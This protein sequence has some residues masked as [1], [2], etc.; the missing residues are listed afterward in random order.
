MRV[1]VALALGG[2]ALGLGLPAGAELRD[3]DVVVLDTGLG[4]IVQIDPATGNRTLFS[5][6]GA[7]P[8]LSGDLGLVQTPDTRVYVTD[9]SFRIVVL[10]DPW[11][12]ARGVASGMLGFSDRGRGPAFGAPGAMDATPDGR[13]LV[14]DPT[15]DAVFAVDARSG[16]RSIL[17][18]NSVGIGP[19]FGPGFGDPNA[20]AR[21]ASGRVLVG[22]GSEQ[23]YGVDPVTGDRTVLTGPAP[24]DESL[25]FRGI[26]DLAAESEPGFLV[27][28]TAQRSLFRVDGSTG[29]RSVVSSSNPA[30]LRGS[31][32]A[33]SLPLGLEVGPRGEILVVDAG[34]RALLAVDPQTGDRRIVSGTGVGTGPAFS[35]PRQVLVSRFPDPGPPGPV[36][37]IDTNSRLYD[38]DLATG[39]AIRRDFVR[40]AAGGFLSG[41][42]IGIDRAPAPDGRLMGLTTAG[43]LYAVDPF[44]A[45][46]RE[47][48]SIGHSIS[49]GDIAFDP[50]TGDLYA[51][52]GTPDGLVLL[53]IDV[54]TGATTRLQSFGGV[55]PDALVFRPDGLLELVD[56]FGKRVFTIDPAS[57]AIL[58]VRP[59]VFRFPG[60]GGRVELQG[61]QG[62]AVW[63]AAAD[64][65]R[66]VGA[67]EVLELPRDAEEGTYRATLGPG[68]VVLSGLTYY[69]NA[70]PTAE[71]GPDQSVE[72]SSPAGAAVTLDGS[73]SADPEGGELAFRWTN[74][75][76]AAEGAQ[77]TVE[78]PL[79]VSLVTL[80]VDDGSGGTGA[81]EVEVRVEDTTPPEV[82]ASLERLRG[83]SRRADR[84]DDDERERWGGKGHRYRVRFACAD[85]CDPAPLALATVDG[86][87]VPDG[88][89]YRPPRDRRSDRDRRGRGRPSP[90]VLSVTC[91]DAS[92]NAAVAEAT[93]PRARPRR[94]R[95]RGG[96]RRRRA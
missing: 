40:D 64:V 31:G 24:A 11:T 25:R 90:L 93:A 77:P 82:T 53:R 30:S 36:L 74:G 80:E 48:A 46:A 71:A 50:A 1:L 9:P 15:A 69:T 45:V 5:S 58:R 88:G 43:R 62:G 13:L 27:L 33:L 8:S 14:S 34:I 3:A 21:E 42:F 73:A 94:R 6:G 47:V 72:C 2:S 32:V 22:V 65:M 70:R 79:G 35:Q 16:D 89:I 81:D 19:G 52:G 54:A 66:I 23:V 51:A 68:L 63:D 87:P 10:I 55:D 17:S 92:G 28:S 20:L 76:G 7:G 78:L 83:R 85:A 86:V 4:A 75:F 44:R 57:G 12:G 18:S 61:P 59:V 26:A 95:R 91:S 37:G 56:S 96:G 38:V 39:D 49:A 67:N 84:D 41:Y 60:G 29:A